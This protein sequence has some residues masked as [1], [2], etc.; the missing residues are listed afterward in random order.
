MTAA[1][2][3]KT[4]ADLL[5]LRHTAPGNGGSGEHAFLTQVRNAAG[6]DASRTFDAVALNLWPSRG[7]TLHVFEIKVSRSDWARE[8]GKP[9]KAEDACRVAD[10]FSI[11]APAGCVKDEELPPTWGLIEV[12][13]EGTTE[14]PWKLRE[15]TP[16]PLLRPRTRGVIPPPLPRGLVVGMLRAAPGAIPGGKL[17][18]ATETEMAEAERRGFDRGIAHQIEVQ[19]RRAGPLARVEENLVAFRDALVAAGMSRWDAEVPALIPHAEAIA[20][21]I[22]HGTNMDRVRQARDTLTRAAAQ[23]TKALNE[24][25]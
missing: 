19:E 20:Q 16:A 12:Q 10:R 3:E 14:K 22:R 15:K 6:F 18:S 4:V 8:L 9:D 2:T 21:A 24:D 11:V 23:L 13:G 1:L 5:R 17:P 25:G 7:L